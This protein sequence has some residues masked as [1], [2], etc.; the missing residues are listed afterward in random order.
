MNETPR[1]RPLTGADLDAVAV[2][3][4]RIWQATY[5]GI[6]P[7]EQIDSMLATRYCDTALRHY[8]NA[9]DRWFELAL[10][11]GSIVGYC[12]CEM[13]DGEY[14]LDKIYVDPARQRSGLGSALIARAADRGRTLGHTAMLLAVNKRNTQAIAAYSKHCFAVRDS[15]CVDI[16][17]GFVMDDYL[18]Q[19]NL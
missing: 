2:L 19:K 17:N 3:A 11:G 7:Q 18:M 14:K 6:I 1:F 15:I 4:R 10:V 12:A 13:V 8:I 16:G 9:S 5:P